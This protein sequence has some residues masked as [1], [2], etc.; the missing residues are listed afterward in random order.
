MRVVGTEADGPRR[1]YFLFSTSTTTMTLLLFAL[2]PPHFGR[3]SLTP[4]SSRTWKSASGLPGDQ[5]NMFPLTDAN[6][7]R[8][9]SFGCFSDQRSFLRIAFPSP[10]PT[11]LV[12]VPVLTAFL[13]CPWRQYRCSHPRRPKPTIVEF[14]YKVAPYLATDHV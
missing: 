9:L 7:S 3:L 13:A 1:R 4:N 11:Q 8:D 2:R 14:F 10:S 5:T 6:E 12:L